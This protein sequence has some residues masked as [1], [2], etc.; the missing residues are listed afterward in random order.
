MTLGVADRMGC[1]I[2]QPIRNVK[3]KSASGK[4][5]NPWFAS[6]LRA[7]LLV[8]CHARVSVNES[9]GCGREALPKRDLSRHTLIYLLLGIGAVSSIFPFWYLFVTSLKPQSYIFEIP[10]SLWPS[11]ATLLN[12]VKALARDSFG[13]YFANSVGVAVVT[14]LVTVACASLLAYAFARMDF[15]LRGV[16]FGLVVVGLMARKQLRAAGDDALVPD[17]KISPSVIFEL[18][19]GY[20]L[21][22]LEDLVGP[23]QARRFLPLV[24]SLFVFILFS[25]LIGLIPGMG[26][27]TST[28]SLNAG[29]AIIVF[30]YYNYVGI[31]E[32]GFGYLKHMMGPIALLAP[33][34]LTI[35]LVGHIV[36]PVTL[37][38]RLAMNMSADHI[39]IGMFTDLTKLIIPVIFMGMGILISVIQALVFCL[40]TG[41]YLQLS[42][43]VCKHEH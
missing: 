33:L 30:V 29:M 9:T 12:Y 41:V 15:P 17:A 27:P 39:V 20:A 40:L 5:L 13:R 38:L 22:M 10:P 32:Q 18:L 24:G 26:S 8:L 31:K 43:G 7:G 25:N 23:Q 1:N 4:G 37:S 35:E 16:L 3:K 42:L 19:T 6:P 2:V 21:N 34:I 28:L 11:E 14:T 36:R